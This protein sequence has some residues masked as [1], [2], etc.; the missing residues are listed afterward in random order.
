M[1][2]TIT[3]GHRDEELI[4]KIKEAKRTLTEEEWRHICYEAISRND[5]KWLDALYYT[6]EDEQEEILAC[7]EERL[8]YELTQGHVCG[9][10]SDLGGLRGKE[11]RGKS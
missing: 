9:F 2:I 7:W 3:P 5:E 6:L 4:S 1:T 11:Y 10:I 8:H